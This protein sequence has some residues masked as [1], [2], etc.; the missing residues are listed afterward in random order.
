MTVDQTVQQARSLMDKG[1]FDEAKSLLKKAAQQAPLREDIKRLL[2]KAIAGVP[3]NS[4]AE[5]EEG[6]GALDQKVAS[7]PTRRKKS[8]SSAR[9]ILTF[10]LIAV[11]FLAAMAG[12]G[13]FFAN[14]GRIPHP[15]R[16]EPTP[17]PDPQTI[18]RQ[19]L[20]DTARQLAARGEMSAAIE[21][22]QQVLET[23]PPNPQQYQSTLAE[24]Y[25]QAGKKAYQASRY[26]PAL[27][28]LEKGLEIQPDS[29]DLLAWA[30]YACYRIGRTG[31][32][33]GRQEKL[34]AA[35][36][37]LKRAIEA[38]PDNLQTYEILA[39][40]YIALGDKVRGSQY[41]QE[42]IRLAPDSPEA[43]E[44]RETLETMGVRV[45]R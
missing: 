20:L 25:L 10:L 38:N 30:G 15:F 28:L 43:R 6:A 14:E 8:R 23:N 21:T 22:M 7:R 27:D 1:N 40:S 36:K 31:P 2:E 29:P 16:A 11:L 19:N 5:P 41:Y 3:S 12:I 42:I 35:T 39:Q 13:F 33:D 26:Q 4:P 24:W 37:L 17:T 18:A 44:A 45:P 32:R 9:W 34:T